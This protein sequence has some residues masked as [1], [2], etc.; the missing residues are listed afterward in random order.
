LDLLE[1]VRAQIEAPNELHVVEGGDHSLV[2]R[3]G[4]LKQMGKTQEQIDNEILAT[5]A[6][7]VASET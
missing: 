2:V 7:F 3:K 5:I 4:D 6:S 1:P